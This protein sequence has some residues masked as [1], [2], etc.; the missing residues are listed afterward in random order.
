MRASISHVNDESMSALD[1]QKEGILKDMEQ[2]NLRKTMKQQGESKE[3][4]RMSV[5]ISAGASTDV[6]FEVFA[7]M[8]NSIGRLRTSL[9]SQQLHKG[10]HSPSSHNSDFEKTLNR[11]SSGLHSSLKVLDALRE[12]IEP[13]GQWAWG[14]YA[15]RFSSDLKK[16]NDFLAEIRVLLISLYGAVSVWVAL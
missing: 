12:N 1:R 2:A 6:A 5:M 13:N 4:Q 15:K 3:D 14:P 8:I 11:I 10:G 16:S 7:E 9:S